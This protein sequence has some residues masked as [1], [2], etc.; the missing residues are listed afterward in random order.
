MF[1]GQDTHCM[2]AC[3][4]S[5]PCPHV[6]LPGPVSPAPISPLSTPCQHPAGAL[7]NLAAEVARCEVVREKVWWIHCHPVTI[8]SPSNNWINQ[9]APDHR[10]MPGHDPRSRGCPTISLVTRHRPCLLMAASAWP[11]LHDLLLRHFMRMDIL[12]LGYFC[13][14]K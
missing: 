14:Q 8:T 5:S 11:L 6:L 3:L 9:T 7:T 10:L 1:V 2:M 4:H 13:K 12:L